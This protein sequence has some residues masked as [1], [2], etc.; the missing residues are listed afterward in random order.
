MMTWSRAAGTAAVET[1]DTSVFG[2]LNLEAT[3]DLH[4]ACGSTVNLPVPP[5]SLTSDKVDAMISEDM[6]RRRGS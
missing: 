2:R 5:L 1:A 6:T 3:N 4:I